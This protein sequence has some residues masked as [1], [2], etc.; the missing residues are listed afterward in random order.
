MNRPIGLP[1]ALPATKLVSSRPDLAA[2]QTE[3]GTSMPAGAVAGVQGVKNDV[4]LPSHAMLEARLP[5]AA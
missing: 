3:V 5:A 1:D 2:L 4:R